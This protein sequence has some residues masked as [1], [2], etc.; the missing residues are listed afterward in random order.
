MLVKKEGKVKLSF[1]S[2]KNRRKMVSETE[3]WKLEG[4]NKSLIAF[5]KVSCF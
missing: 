2:W 1:K 4:D 5:Q 3:L